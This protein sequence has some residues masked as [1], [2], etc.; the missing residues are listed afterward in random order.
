MTKKKL[1]SIVSN[2]S[3]IYHEFNLKKL[4]AGKTT[5]KIRSEI[6]QATLNFY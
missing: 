5:V 6:I 1:V 3:I 4:I 2:K